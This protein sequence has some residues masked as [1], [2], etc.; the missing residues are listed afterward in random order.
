[1][2]FSFP[3]SGELIRIFN[4][5]RLTYLCGIY[6]TEIAVL[7]SRRRSMDKFAAADSAG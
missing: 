3:P 4:A 1:M 5:G 6:L 2:F 7:H